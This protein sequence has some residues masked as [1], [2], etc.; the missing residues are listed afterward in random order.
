MPRSLLAVQNKKE[1]GT[2]KTFIYYLSV[3]IYFDDDFYVFA[4]DQR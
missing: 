3:I 2:D 1:P 4:I